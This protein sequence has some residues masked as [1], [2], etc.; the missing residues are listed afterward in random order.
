MLR[1]SDVMDTIDLDGKIHLALV[2]CKDINSDLPR[3]ST[4]AL[5]EV[6]L[7]FSK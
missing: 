1:R 2:H 5:N 3:L 4:P 7:L 6:N